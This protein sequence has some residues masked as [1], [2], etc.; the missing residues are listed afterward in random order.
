MNSRYNI[1]GLRAFWRKLL[2]L[3][4]EHLYS[5]A[6]RTLGRI[7]NIILF[8]LI[9]STTASL[10]NEIIQQHFYGSIISGF[11][12]SIIFLLSFLKF[13]GKLW[14]SSFLF[15]LILPLGIT[16]LMV[17]YSDVKFSVFYY[18]AF[19]Y[20]GVL[21]SPKNGVKYLF[22][23]YNVFLF[24]FTQ[25]FQMSCDPIMGNSFHALSNAAVLLNFTFVFL[26][27]IFQI[28]N[29][30]I[31]AGIEIDALNQELHTQ[32][33]NLSKEKDELMRLVSHDL[34]A[35]LRTIG[36]FTKLIERG[37]KP[38]STPELDEYCAFVFKG[39]ENMEKMIKESLLIAKTN[40][41]S[42]LKTESIDLNCLVEEIESDLTSKYNNFT[43]TK[44][45][46]PTIQS[47]Y[48]IYKKIFLNIIQN[49]IKY[50]TSAL[51]R[52]KISFL[53]ENGFFVYIIEDNGIG[54]PKEQHDSVFEMYNRGSHSTE[55]EGTGIGLAITKQMVESLNGKIQ[56]NSAKDVGS[57]FTVS[58][59][60]I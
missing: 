48:V 41:I 28:E 39:V 49:G 31:N 21:Y 1:T 4:N 24:C 46:L 7:F 35:P 59:P 5:R 19:I 53:R 51:K 34:R 42:Q 44:E 26:F 10:A 43:L 2:D 36:G 27:L 54:I 22:V 32:N 60:S 38:Y 20:S 56:V 16:S 15:N 52:I 6:H 29:K 40:N 12:C 25:W 33:Q 8:I 17:L 47:H 57:I 9:F 18:F 55:Y 45:N 30:L 58:L 50:N 14:I 3:G 23:A 13:R 37:V 11:I